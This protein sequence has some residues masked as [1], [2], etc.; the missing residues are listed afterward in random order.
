[1]IIV[2]QFDFNVLLC[3]DRLLSKFKG[4]TRPCYLSN[5]VSRKEMTLYFLKSKI[6][7]YVQLNKA[8]IKNLSSLI[9]ILA[10]I[11]FRL[12]AHLQTKKN[13]YFS[14]KRSV[15]ISANT[16][17]ILPKMYTDCSFLFDKTYMNFRVTMQET[18]KQVLRRLRTLKILFITEMQTDQRNIVCEMICL[19]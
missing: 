8:R 16:L 12:P 4:S 9:P 1:M 19:N 7:K 10:L 6:M 5:G 18:D 13:Q 2:K 11:T 17:L 15:V 14:Q 3:V